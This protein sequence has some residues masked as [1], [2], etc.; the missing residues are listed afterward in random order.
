M[1]APIEEQFVEIDGIRVFCRRRRGEGVPTIWIHGN[2]TNSDD[3][4]PFLVA[5]SGPAIA[6]DLPGFGRSEHPDPGRF[7]CTVGSY[8]RF[9]A[10]AFA[11][12]APDGYELVVHDWGTVG[13]VGAQ[14][15]PEAVRSLVVI[16]AV[17][18]TSTYR[19]H[20]V[21][22]VWRRRG[23]GEAFSRARSRF[24]TAQLLRLARPGRRP[25]P[26]ELV[27][28]VLE[29]W[30]E[31]MSRAILALYRSADPDM[32]EAAGERLGEI[33]CPALVLWGEDDPYISPA[34][35]RSFAA[36]LP[37]ARFELVERAGH[38]PWIDRPEVIDRVA[39]F[40][41]DARS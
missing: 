16:D 26:P 35:G 30:D 15:R 20:W 13:L 3:W 12:L 17:P 41:A 39:R 24:L 23:L 28:M 10:R 8:G 33:R 11:E 37:A 7:D 31:G 40:L 5:T 4:L 25:M 32:L 21:A 36:A 19:W 18:L 6:V 27:D 22:R 1:A 34:D 2:P 29:H 14:A 38:W 9:L